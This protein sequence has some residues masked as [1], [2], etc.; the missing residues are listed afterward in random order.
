MSR[1]AVSQPHESAAVAAVAAMP[2]ALD[3][4][5]IAERQ[6]GCAE[7]Q[8][9]AAAS[10]LRVRPVEVNGTAVLCDI[11]TGANQP[12]IP[13]EDRRAIF[14]AF[15]CLAH[16]GVRATRR[17]LA[18]RVVWP[19]IAADIGRWCR[20]C[21]DCA[22]GKVS[23]QLAAA[24]VPIPVPRQ[25]FSHIHVDLVGPLPVSAEGFSYLFTVIDR[26]T[27]WL[28][29]VPLKNMEA[30]TCADALVDTWISRFGVPASDRGTQFCSAIWNVL[31]STLKIQHITTTAFHPQ[32]NGMIERAH[33]QL[34]D[35]LRARL[36]GM[37]WP[38]HLPWVLLGLRAVPKDSSTISSSEM[39]FGAAISLPNQLQTPVERPVDEFVQRLKET[40]PPPTRV[41][42]PPPPIVPPHL[43][44][45]CYVY[46]RRG[47]K[48]SPLS[49]VYQG[50]FEVVEAGPKH[51]LL[52]VG[53]QLETVSVDRLKPHLGQDPVAPAEP[54]RR[55][56]PKLAGSLTISGA[57]QP[58][59][60]A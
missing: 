51:V 59:S 20:D 48:P 1:P 37:E 42:S 57:V 41:R 13:V 26:S 16:P 15:H 50:P 38:Q 52:R 58:P 21:Q 22:R 56:W 43:I 30:R 12:L 54:A 18:V 27:R 45:A 3:Y 11:S 24:M 39:V 5:A 10:A 19:D 46:I 23:A 6:R 29:A 49:P 36:A 28:Q 55:G 60:V 44:A 2:A 47:G 14:T 25:R 31:C 40:I 53:S 33:R 9:A 34:K 17:L 4:A 35:A 32:S 7:T 8:Q